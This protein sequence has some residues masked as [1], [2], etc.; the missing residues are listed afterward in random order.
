MDQFWTIRTRRK[1]LKNG[2]WTASTPAVKDYYINYGNLF[3][4]VITVLSYN[5]YVPLFVI[6]HVI[7]SGYRYIYKQCGKSYSFFVI[8]HYSYHCALRL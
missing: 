6:F 2:N 8:T 3:R 5:D 4:Y 7:Q 1:K